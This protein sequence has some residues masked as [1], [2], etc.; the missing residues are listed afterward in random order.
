MSKQVVQR[1]NIDLT[2]GAQSSRVSSGNRQ[3]LMQQRQPSSDEL[4]IK[5]I[6]DKMKTRGA[7]GIMGMGRKFRIYDD[8]GD[9]TLGPQEFQKAMTELRMGL[10]DQ[11]I[12]IAFGIFDRDHGGSVDYDEFLRT[13]RGEMN[14]GRTRLAMQAF[15]KLDKDGSG[16]IDIHDIHGVYNAKKHPDVIQGKKTEDEVLTEFLETFESHHT[17]NVDS[18][19]DGNVTQAEF[20]EYY[21]FISMS[22]DDDRYFEL[23]MTNA[24]NLDGSRTNVRKAQA[25]QY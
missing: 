6:V 1:A 15:N 16:V 9:K 25:F 12:T 19:R 5:K 20:I 11:E 17:P 22:I 2:S 23:M 21:N 3:S 8:N 18:V 4:L 13:I 14:Q 24:W 10:T 7:T